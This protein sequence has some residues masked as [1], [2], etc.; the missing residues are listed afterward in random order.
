MTERPIIMSAESVRALLAGKT[1]QTR[2][3]IKPQPDNYAYAEQIYAE[4]YS[5]YRQIYCP[6]GVPGDRLWV[7][8]TWMITVGAQLVYKATPEKPWRVCGNGESSAFTRLD[9]WRSPLHMPRWASRLT[10]EVKDVRIQRLQEAEFYDIRAE[11]IDCPT[12]DFPGGFCCSECGDL[13]SAFCSK[14]DALNAKRGFPWESNPF[15]WCI[16][17]ERLEARPMTHGQVTVFCDYPECSANLT[18]GLTRCTHGQWDERNL[19]KELQQEGWR[20]KEG[21]HL[22]PKHRRRRI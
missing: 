20:I 12:H 8:E 21:Y 19:E 13:R 14:W 22:C 11:G 16:T 5:P 4:C 6:Y 3:V 2:R 10:L 18:T 17:F 1:T 15:C 9:E 7:K